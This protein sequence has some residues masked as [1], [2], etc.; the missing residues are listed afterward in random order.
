MIDKRACQFVLGP[1]V[2]ALRS[3]RLRGGGQRKKRTGYFEAILYKMPLDSR[4]S[5]YNLDSGVDVT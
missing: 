2:S 4:S 1:G 3:G 5:F